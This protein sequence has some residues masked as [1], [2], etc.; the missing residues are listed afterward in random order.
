MRVTVHSIGAVGAPGGR[1]V[2]RGRAGETI[3]SA[4]VPALKAPVD[5]LPK[6]ADVVLPLP[7]N[8][9]WKGGSVTVE[10]GGDLPEITLRNNRVELP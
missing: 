7:S 2:L 1:I 4:A 6:T 9:S 8:A 5:L 3:T 10:I